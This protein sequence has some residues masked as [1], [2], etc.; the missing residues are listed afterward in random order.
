MLK[1]WFKTGSPV[2]S[3]EEKQRLSQEIFAACEIGP[4]GWQDCWLYPKKNGSAYGMKSIGGKTYTVSR[5][6]LAIHTGESFDVKADA[7]HHHDICPYPNCCNPSHLFWDS[8]SNNC[9]E[10]E[11]RKKEDMRLFKFWETHAWVNGV[12]FSDRMDPG[13][14]YY[15][16]ENPKHDL[17]CLGD[18]KTAVGT[19]VTPAFATDNISI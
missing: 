17:E 2:L 6:M 8:R 7:C 15:G 3:L 4:N 10:R 9:V 16:Q 5:I 1:K 13:L 14:T 18:S 12:F 11:A 19:E